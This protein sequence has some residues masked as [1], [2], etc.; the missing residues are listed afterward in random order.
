MRRIFRPV[1]L[2]SSIFLRRRIYQMLPQISRDTGNQ[3]KADGG[4]GQG[5]QGCSI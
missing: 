4:A 3:G 2:F 5:Q 1:G